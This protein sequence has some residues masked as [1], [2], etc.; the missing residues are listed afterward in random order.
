MEDSGRC[1]AI[2]VDFTSSRVSAPLAS[3]PR[4]SLAKGWDSTGVT[5][6][7]LATGMLSRERLGATNPTFMLGF[8]ANSGATGVSDARLFSSAATASEVAVPSDASAA[9]SR[10]ETGWIADTKGGVDAFTD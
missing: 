4:A 9:S 10:S 6:A 2:P 8:D 1:A 5:I 7:G 3:D